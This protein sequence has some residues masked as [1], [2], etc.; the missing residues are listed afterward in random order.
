MCR[1]FWRIVYSP[2]RRGHPALEDSG[3]GA[4]ALYRIQCRR[5]PPTNANDSLKKMPR[6]GSQRTMPPQGC[7]FLQH[8][9]SITASPKTTTQRSSSPPEASSLRE[10]VPFHP[11]TTPPQALR[12]QQRTKPPPSNLSEPSRALPGEIKFKDR[13]SHYS[14]QT[15]TFPSPQQTLPTTSMPMAFT[16]ASPLRSSSEHPQKLTS[17]SPST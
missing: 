8:R 14:Q 17:R 13:L 3:G 4:V 7:P 2:P 11:Y 16:S 15:S 12:A 5:L 6:Q 1:V 10:L 9:L